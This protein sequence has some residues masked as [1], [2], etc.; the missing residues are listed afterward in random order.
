MSVFSSTG[1]LT[2]AQADESTAAL[3]HLLGTQNPLDVLRETPATL[4]GELDHI[5]PAKL[6]T[7]EAPGKW[8]ARMV[9]AH[10]ADSELVGAFRLRMILAHDTPALA[11]Y[12]QDLWATR[13][14]YEHADLEQSLE[15]FSVLRRANLTLWATASSADLARVGVHGERGEESIE[16][17]RRLYAGHDLAHLRQLARI[18]ILLTGQ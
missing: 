7:P 18:R 9:I 13:L 4:R 16:R 1:V 17:M 8:S 15:R 3:L 11:P 5:P 12:D 2:P 14:K 10:L 6:G